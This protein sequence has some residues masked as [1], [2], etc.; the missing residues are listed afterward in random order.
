LSAGDIALKAENSAKYR[1]FRQT[2]DPQGKTG[3]GYLLQVW[4]KYNS[5]IQQ[6]RRFPGGNWIV[7][8][9]QTPTNILKQGVEYSPL[10]LAT[11]PGSKN[12][13]EQLSK[14]IIGSA[15]FAGTYGLLNKLEFT[16]D[17]PTGQ[18]ERDLFYAANMMPYSVKIGNQW[19]SFSKLG[20]LSYPMA[21]AAALRY[22]EKYDLPTDKE[23]AI[24]TAVGG[25]L[26]F[27]SDQSYVKQL[28][29]FI[30]SVQTG[31]GV[32]G[33]LK[34]EATNAV[35]QMIPYKSFLGW[36]SRMIDPVSRKSTGVVSSVASQLPW[37]SKTVE[38][39]YNPVTRKPSERSNPLFNSFSPIRVNTGN[40]GVESM[41]KYTGSAKRAYSNLK[42]LPPPEAAK[43]FAKIQQSSPAIATGILKL[44]KEVNAGVTGEDRTLKSLSAGDGERAFAIFNKLNKLKTPQEKAK[45]WAEY[46]K[47][48]IINDEVGEQI[49]QMYSNR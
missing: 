11:I 36:L 12:A 35:S 39:Y 3:Q 43:M 1:L 8:F 6:L 23:S 5:V 30:D 13:I 33:G 46:V 18:K 37:L 49:K 2:F 22:A 40:T 21:M 20:P 7:P 24:S 10:G 16:W 41:Y 47:K 45:L 32:I 9:L 31:K 26:K 48:G 44:A 42:L 25:M 17:V 27:Y 19:V 15:V 29:D 38:P 34:M 14:T 4:D 28:G